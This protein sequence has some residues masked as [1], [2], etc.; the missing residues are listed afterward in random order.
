MGIKQRHNNWFMHIF[1]YPVVVKDLLMSFVHEDFVKDLEFASLKKLNPDFFPASG[2]SR[3][4]DVIYEITSHGQTSYIYIFIEFQSTVDWFMPLRMARYMLEFYD[5]LRR[6]GKQKFL[7]PS[8][9]ILLYNGEPIWN[10]PEN[11]SDL[12]LD[13]SIPKEFLPEFRYYKIAINEIP[14][15]DLLRLRNAVSAVF[16]I[17]NSNPSEINKNYDELV[18]ILREVIK[19]TCGVE[20][21]QQIMNRIFEIYRLP[22]NSKTITSIEDIMEAKNMLETKTKIWEKEILEKGIKKGI[23]KTAINMIKIGETDSKI[24]LC[25]GLS[26]EQIV[27]LRNRIQKE[28]R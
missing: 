4:A 11:L 13:S 15:R 17:E 10:A 25:T 27:E 14:K 22:Q 23:E 3:H 8:F 24:A 19:K 2:K 28:N 21:I 5:E 18:Y 26:I 12:F 1:N 6:S 9:A 20:I 16:F 7:N